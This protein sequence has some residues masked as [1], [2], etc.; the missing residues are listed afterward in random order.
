MNCQYVF[1]YSLEQTCIAEYFDNVLYELREGTKI[2]RLVA[3]SY[4]TC[5]LELTIAAGRKKRNDQ[6]FTILCLRK[7]RLSYMLEQRELNSKRANVATDN[8]STRH[9]PHTHT[10]TPSFTRPFSF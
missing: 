4:W 6:A 10:C 2:N 5:S 9:N 7:D 1:V 8:C 3:G